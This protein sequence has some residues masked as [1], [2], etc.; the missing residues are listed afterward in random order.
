MEH[1]A[2]KSPF[3]IVVLGGFNVRMQGCYQNDKTTFKVR[4]VKDRYGNYSAQ[5]VPNNKRT[6]LCFSNSASCIDLIF[7]S[8]PKLAMHSGVHPSLHPNCHHQ[9][10]FVKLNLTIFYCPPYK[11]LVWHYQQANTDLIKR[12]IKL[13]EW[14]KKSL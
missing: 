13:F 14:E 6:N 5:F 8:Q 3:L 10:V 12:K 11:W 1:V 2:N 4:R 9:I 7:T